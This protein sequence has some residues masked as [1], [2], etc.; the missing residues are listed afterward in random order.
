ML[1]IETLA[2]ARTYANKIGES[3]SGK[4][5][6]QIV[7]SL[8]ETGDPS[9]I[10][11]VKKEN[12]SVEDD[13]YDEYLWIEG[14]YEHIG[15]TATTMVVDGE[16]SD[17]S[18]NPVQN[19]VIKGELDKKVNKP[20]TIEEGVLCYNSMGKEIV[21]GLTGSGV[22]V[23]ID[24]NNIPDNNAVKEYVGTKI[25]NKVDKVDGKTLSS[26]D[27]TDDDKTKL[28]SLENYNDSEI[29]ESLENKVDKPTVSDTDTVVVLYSSSSGTSSKKITSSLSASSTN[30]TI[31]TSKSV[32]DYVKAQKTDITI[33]SALSD[34][35]ENPVQNK[36]IKAELD[37]RLEEPT[38]NP[39]NV[40][41]VIY[42]PSTTETH[43]YTLDSSALTEGTAG[44]NKIP[45]SY[46]VSQ[47]ITKISKV[48]TVNLVDNA[49]TL[50]FAD[51]I[52]STFIIPN[53][54]NK[55]E[56]TFGIESD[57]KD[58]YVGR[59]IIVDF[60]NEM[61]PASIRTYSGN[62]NIKY[63]D[64]EPESVSFGTLIEATLVKSSSS[65]GSDI[66]YV[67]YVSYE[68]I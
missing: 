3:L 55:S 1:S 20:A 53:G 32:I 12:S 58:E 8:P 24:L 29:K 15:S 67:V 9:V 54:A 46:A 4:L 56:I 19:K 62:S 28:D 44:L 52:V 40:S 65:T 34:S 42:N 39:N 7:D 22:S 18:E 38:D 57:F 11:L 41:V 50:S 10:Y 17:E 2:L 36:I 31:P 33:D 13:V 35:S 6:R 21:R 37:K 60:L 27:F 47:A 59:K 26:N 14:K 66:A 49:I 63:K 5:T 45:T 61:F 23:E 16:L 30:A 43:G 25:K 51:A 48:S 64:T 68:K